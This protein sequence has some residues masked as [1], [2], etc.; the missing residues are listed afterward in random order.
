M[1]IFT[2]F[3]A[4][5]RARKLTRQF[6]EIERRVQTMSPRSRNRLSTLTQR[7]ISQAARSDFPHLYGTSPELRYLPWGQGTDAGYERAF[8]AT[9]EVALRGMA[10]WLAVA[11]HETRNSP[12][13]SLQ[14]QYRQLMRLLHQLKELSHS[15]DTIENWMRAGAAA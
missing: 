5:M 4:M 12:H 14:P 13:A 9:N 15:K 2:P 10:L 8:S 1:Q 3:I 6:R 11:Y 7:E